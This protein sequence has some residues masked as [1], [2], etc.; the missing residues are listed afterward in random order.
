M[1]TVEEAEALKALMDEQKY[2]QE[3][4]ST[5]IGKARSTVAEILTLNRLPEE[6]R[7]ECRNNSAISRATL[8][9][10]AR[11]KQ[12]RSEVDPVQQI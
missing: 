11:N 4:L 5:M 1:S 10:I 6:I 2:T 8:L 3:Q 7:T 12:T 9:Q